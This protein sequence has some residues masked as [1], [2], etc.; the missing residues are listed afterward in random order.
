[1]AYTFGTMVLSGL[2]YSPAGAVDSHSCPGETVMRRFRGFTLIELLVVIA[3]IGILA[4]ILLPALA[5][6]REAARRSSCQNN[7]KQMGLVFNMYANESKEVFPP[8]RRLT[9]ENKAARDATFDG[10]SLYPEYL[11]DVKTCVCPSDS[12]GDTVLKGLHVDN[13]LSKPVLV[14]NLA[15]GSYYYLGWA[16]MEQAVLKPGVVPPT[17]QEFQQQHLNGA[18]DILNYATTFLDDSLIAGGMT[19]YLAWVA[20]D[21]AKTNQQKDAALGPIPRLRIGVERFFITDI[22]NSAAGSL[23][24]G[25]IPVMWDEIAVYGSA[26]TFNHVPGGG[27]VVY[28]DGHAEFLKWPSTYP[29]NI[30][31]VLL[32]VLF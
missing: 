11:T 1:M 10:P 14:C 30:L 18:T 32:S 16:F 15:R 27:N 9:C 25:Q 6:A 31:G 3:I 21:V 28:M 24:A 5:R 22:N 29:A 2:L 4:A 23:A 8:I 19:F 17:L 20:N 12:D 7:L 26:T 13:D